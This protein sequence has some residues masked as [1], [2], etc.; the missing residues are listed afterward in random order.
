MRNG[1][2]LRAF[3]KWFLFVFAKIK[4]FVSFPQAEPLLHIHDTSEWILLMIIDSVFLHSLTLAHSYYSSLRGRGGSISFDSLLFRLEY[5]KTINFRLLIQL[6]Q[7]I[8][9]DSYATTEG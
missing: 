1:V 5:S 3:A 2:R 6:L 4:L 7:I 9:S 8:L